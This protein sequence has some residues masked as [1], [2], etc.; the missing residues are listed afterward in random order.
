[1][2]IAIEPETFVPQEATASSF[3]RSTIMAVI[4]APFACKGG[5]FTGNRDTVG[6]LRPTGMRDMPACWIAAS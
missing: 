1:M 2:Q 4:L 6:Y 3:S 5:H